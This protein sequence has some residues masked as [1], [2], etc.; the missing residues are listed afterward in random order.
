VDGDINLTTGH[1]FK[2]DGVEITSGGGGITQAQLDEKANTTDVNTQLGLKLNKTG[3]N[4]ILN[5]L[6]LNSDN[7]RLGNFTTGNSTSIDIG[8]GAGST[9][10]VRHVGIGFDAYKDGAAAD[11]SIAIGTN[12]GRGVQRASS[13]NIG[14]SAGQTWSTGANGI[15]LG[16]SAHASGSI[17][18]T[19][20]INATGA[21]LRN[22]IS[23]TCLIKPIREETVSLTGFIPM[24]YNSVTGE[25]VSSNLTYP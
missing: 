6:Q 14:T 8:R 1:A 13:I 7:V 9:S 15:C 16:K 12:A 21:T 23:N 11:D 25:L 4:V 24:F 17:P 5:S 22:Q 3:D 2:I 18:N 20:V 19:L 10:G